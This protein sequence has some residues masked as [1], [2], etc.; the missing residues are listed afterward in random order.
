V[1]VVEAAGEVLWVAGL[2]RSATAPI[3]E[4]TRRVLVLSLV[5]GQAARTAQ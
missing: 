2:R 1:P 4:H 3:T 5:Q